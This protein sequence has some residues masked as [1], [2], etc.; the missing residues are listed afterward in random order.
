MARANRAIIELAARDT[1]GAA[2]STVAGKFRGLQGNIDGLASKF[3]GLQGTIAAA[4]SGFGV[5]AL[6]TGIAD[7]LDAFNDLSDATG[8]SIENISRLENAARRTGGSF[9]DVSTALLKFNQALN[10]AKIGTEQA[11]VFNALGLSVEEL[12]RAD[13]AEALLTTAKALQTFQADGSSA[14]AEAILFGRSVATLAPLLKD[15]AA[16]GAANGTVL[17]SQAQAAEDFNKSLARLSASI[18]NVGRDVVSDFL[19]NIT[20]AFVRLEAMSRVFGSIGSGLKFLLL[21]DRVADAGSGI[22]QYTRE[23]QNLQAQRKKLETGGS[24]FDKINL[25]KIDE[26]IAEAEKLLAYYRT[27]FAATAPDLG[28]SDPRELAR[29]GRPVRGGASL[30]IPDPGPKTRPAASPGR[31]LLPELAEADLAALRALESTDIA[32]IAALDQQLESLFTLQRETRGTS[33]AVAQA[34]DETRAALARLDPA[35]QQA[36]EIRQQIDALV[37]ASTGA[38]FDGLVTLT[39]RLVEEMNAG[40]VSATDYARAVEVLGLRFKELEPAGTETLAKL[41]TAAEDAGKDIQDT[42]G[43]TL[44]R[45]LRGDFD[46]IGDLWASLLAQMAADAAK[47]QLSQFFNLGSLVSGASGVG[48]FLGS[49]F[50][51]FRAAGGPVQAGKAYIVGERGPEMIVPSSS[52]TVIPNGAAGGVSITYGSINIGEGVSRAEVYSAI[53]RANRNAEARMR[54]VLARNQLPVA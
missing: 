18:Q 43:N 15:V 35:A 12:R 7:G 13:P 30:D 26:R 17:R 51:G 32:R 14:R 45:V 31:R 42:L 10:G 40:R 2:F 3:V 22:A 24:I 8:S 52:G 34:I 44:A 53:E 36:A 54:Q 29:R 9:E 49:L 46:S 19:P 39:E 6:I 20:E 1:T 11:A 23:L 28:Q 25:P 38:K 37:G 5:G 41:G 27:I 16:D 21:E 50:G 47:A 4:I 48:G 33:P